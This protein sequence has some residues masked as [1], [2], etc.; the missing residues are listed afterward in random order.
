MLVAQAR[1]AEASVRDLSLRSANTTRLDALADRAGR[2]ADLRITYIDPGGKVVGDSMVETARLAELDDHAARPEVERALR[3]EV[4]SIMRWSD[5][6]KRHLFYVAVPVQAEG[7]G[8]VRVAMEIE[9]VDALLARVRRR[10][11]LSAILG[12][13]LALAVGLALLRYPM[14]PLDEL[15]SALARLGRGELTVGLSPRASDDL[16]ALSTAV[17]EVSRTLRR[18][19]A[20][21]MTENEQMEAVI[22]SMVEGVLIVDRRGDVVMANPRLRDFLSLRGDVTGRPAF[23]LVRTS[24]ISEAL[25][26][27]L[28]SGELVA[29]EIRRVGPESRTLLVHAVGFPAEGERA[30][31]V[32]VLHDVTELHRVDAVRRDFVANASHELRTPL[33]AIRGFAETLLAG[34]D[35]SD[36]Q[37]RYLEVIARNAQRMALLIEDLLELSRI[38]SG[39]HPVAIEPVDAIAAARDVLTDLSGR[40]SEKQLETRL[41]APP[42]PL[43]AAADPRALGQ[44]LSN[45]LDNAIK[46][47]DAGGVVTLSIDETPDGVELC[48]EDTGAGIPE[49][50]RARI[51]ERFYRVDAARS[52]ALGGTGLGLAIVKHL[53]QAMGGEIGV[54]SELARGSRFTVRLRR[55]GPP[56][57]A[58]DERDASP[59]VGNAPGSASP[60]R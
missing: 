21:A 13:G 4:G 59:P 28:G 15:R 6:V 27:A 52:R 17:H 44:V 60:P 34:A 30:G 7:G 8:V 16:G 45:L 9:R 3:G 51:F 36:E 14:R 55:S 50:D 23:E 54:E 10:V 11:L 18:Q 31:A 12:T 38:E 42:G 57:P 25:R 37:H 22:S 49:E 47:T 48:V 41:Q 32:A 39:R 35:E 53:V 56:E 43:W 29:R 24:E 2:A 33:T 19:Q 58:A 46:Y 40:A 20:E 26:D 5:T 1:L